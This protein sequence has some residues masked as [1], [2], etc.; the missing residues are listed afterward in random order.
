MTQDYRLVFVEEGGGQISYELAAGAFAPVAPGSSLPAG[1]LQILVLPSMTSLPFLVELPFSDPAKIAR[2]LPQFVA[3]QY[4]DVDENWLFSWQAMPLPSREKGCQVAGLAFPA[5]CAA[6]LRS[7][8]NQF[9]LAIP[10]L[11]L[12]GASTGQAV[13]LKTPVSEVIGIFNGPYAVK[14][15]FSL[16]SGLP[17]DMLLVSEGVEAMVDVDLTLDCSALVARIERLFA[18]E[19]ASIDVSGFSSSRRQSL[20]HLAFSLAAFVV[21]IWVVLWHWFV[22]LECRITERAAQRT[23]THMQQ[24]FSA[25][26]PGIPV[27]EPLTQVSR[28]IAE[29]EKRLKEAAIVPKL[30]WQ[31]LA[32][33]VETTSGPDTVLLRITARESNLRLGGLAVNYA[34]LEHLRSRLEGAGLFERVTT[35]ESRQGDGGITFSLEAPWKK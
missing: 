3:D 8:G 23:R 35:V 17:V 16:S 12:A 22:W 24:A 7:S 32:K 6:L 13:R 20:I 28:S 4:V 30:P 19:N 21:V 26:F 29:L 5:Q 33:L 11:F 25:T 18:P 9:R 2:V 1:A 14:R 27:V 10:D 15:L 31:S 34:A